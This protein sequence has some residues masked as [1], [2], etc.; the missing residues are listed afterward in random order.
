MENQVEKDI[1]LIINEYKDKVHGILAFSYFL[2]LAFFLVGV[3]LDSVFNLNIFRSTLF[4]YAGGL[5]IIL[6]T[7]LIFWAQKTSRNL[8]KTTLTKES[9]CKGPYRFTRIPTHWGLFFLMIGFG[10][11]NNGV[12]MILLTLFSYFVT[13]YG[14]LKKEEDILE[15]KYG[16]PYLEYK[17]SV[18][19]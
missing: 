5:L 13:K 3:F 6:A 12:F 15:K 1:K 4:V 18:K 19:S 8:K 17:K 11:V 7:A 16:A 9:F 2:Y 10:F 14:F